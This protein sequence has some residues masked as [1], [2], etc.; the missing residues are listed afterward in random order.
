MIYLADVNLLLALAWPQHSHHQRA[1]AWWNSLT[2]QD[3]LATCAI[4][5]LG[6]VRI[7]MQTPVVRVDILT[8]RKALAR[9]CAAG[10][11]HLFLPDT[12]GVDALPAWVKAASQTTDGHLVTLAAAQGARLVT[13]D[14]GIPGSVLI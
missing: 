13:L 4:T 11:G 12:V 3:R 1:L 10:R 5:E 7:S 9:L 8:A 2:A 6:F 14:A